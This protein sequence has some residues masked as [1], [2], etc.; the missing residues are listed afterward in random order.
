MIHWGQFAQTKVWFAAKVAA[1][2][3]CSYSNREL[4]KNGRNKRHTLRKASFCSRCLLIKGMTWSI[5]DAGPSL[6]RPPHQ[7]SSLRY[8][9]SKLSSTLQTCGT[10]QDTDAIKATITS[11]E[12]S[13]QELQPTINQK[14]TGSH[15]ASCGISNYRGIWQM[16][17]NGPCIPA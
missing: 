3:F 7:S 11:T 17:S 12:D 10:I 14:E 5:S 13:L 6:S 1:R 16:T 2:H 4:L 9:C 8:S 15:I